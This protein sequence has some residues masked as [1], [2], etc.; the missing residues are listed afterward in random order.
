MSQKTTGKKKTTGFLNCLTLR[1]R[2]KLIELIKVH[3]ESL[4]IDDPDVIT[5]N[6]KMGRVALAF[7][8]NLVFDSKGN[9]PN[10][11]NRDYRENAIFSRHWYSQIEDLIK[12]RENSKIAPL[13]YFEH[14]DGRRKSCTCE[15]V[16]CLS[17]IKDALS[18]EIGWIYIDTLISK[19]RVNERAKNKRGFPYRL[20]ET[21]SMQYH[22]PEVYALLH[23]INESQQ[24]KDQIYEAEA[25]LTGDDQEKAEKAIDEFFNATF[26]LREIGD[27][28]KFLTDKPQK[29]DF[30]KKLREE[31]SEEKI[32]ELR[33]VRELREALD[34]ENVNEPEDDGEKEDYRISELSDFE[35][36]EEISLRSKPRAHRPLYYRVEAIL[37]E[38]IVTLFSPQG[39]Q[40]W[41]TELTGESHTGKTEETINKALSDNKD[42]LIDGALKRMQDRLIFDLLTSVPS[43]LKERLNIENSNRKTP[44]TRPDL[45]D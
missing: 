45:D 43:A 25:N 38:E 14:D 13:P 19:E 22:D 16:W 36:E 31:L 37:H 7:L 30:I 20:E 3:A 41:Y 24:K 34:D 26:N 8:Y 40:T 32:N 27:V 28:L 6:N 21:R 39:R 1:K 17:L 5:I 42:D 18:P 15:A 44:G 11:Y 29:G 12:N 9:I 23:E 2:K 10:P 4:Y 35:E 33:K